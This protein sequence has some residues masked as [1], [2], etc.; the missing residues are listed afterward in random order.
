[1]SD[2]RI[3]K[4][5]SVVPFLLLLA[6]L[7]WGQYLLA[8]PLIQEWRTTNGVQVLFVA[9]P[10]L[11]MLDVHVAFDAGSA[12]DGERPGI[13]Q[14]TNAL[15]KDGA[16][17]WNADQIADRMA[18]VGA[19]LGS[20]SL[21]DM[22]WVSLRTLTEPKPL[23]TSVE[24][25]ARILAAPR[26]DA[27]ALERNRQMMQA[28]LLQEAQSPGPVAQRAFFKKVF[29]E[30]PY[31]I[32]DAG[33]RES[34]AAITRREV[35][36][37]HA[38]YYVA[39]NATVAMVGA[40]DRARAEAIAEQITAG[41][42]LGMQV[43]TL[44]EVA[45]LTRGE[46]IHIPF[47][48]SQSHILLGQPGM[49]RGDPDYF[50]L[51]VGNHILGG[52]G[53]VSLLSEEVREKRGL[54]Y[55]V[56]SY[57]SPMRRNGPFVMAAQTK[58]ATTEEVLTV[59]RETLRRFIDNG[60]TEKELMA[61]KQNI[62]GGFPLRISSNSKIVRYLAMLGF[63]RLPLDYLDTFVAKINGVTRKQVREA[64]QRRLHP[65]RFVSLVVGNGEQAAAA[66]K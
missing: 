18:S 63:Y 11:P 34:L 29:G 28:V 32:H 57:F 15:L 48:S 56:Y 12:R 23:E 25:L 1:M 20:G 65:D 47:P 24:T 26:F 30:H 55:S 39:R 62:T 36:A 13:S 10:D 22:A 66:L 58:N 46:E 37:H 17:E 42:P 45:D 64:F 59:M 43:P 19:K 53:M 16:G 35:Q 60:P 14:F 6:G 40:L 7:L 4:Q 52:G 21:R 27:D 5:W 54:S 44:P 9:A 49:R 33:T 3:C 41:L 8:G 31:A 2:K 50:V 38:R 61:A 51:Y